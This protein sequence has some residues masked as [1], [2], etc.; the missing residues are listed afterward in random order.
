MAVIRKTKK[1]YGMQRGGFFGKLKGLLKKPQKTVVAFKNPM[2]EGLKPNLH[3]NPLYNSKGE[4]AQHYETVSNNQKSISRQGSHSAINAFSKT[5]PKLPLTPTELDTNK[6]KD[7]IIA[8]QKAYIVNPLEIKTSSPI[9]TSSGEKTSFYNIKKMKNYLVKQG[10]TGNNH[11]NRLISDI[12]QTG[13]SEVSKQAKLDFNKQAFR[14]AREFSTEKFIKSMPSERQE[15]IRNYI[16]KPDSYMKNVRSKTLNKYF[17]NI[18]PNNNSKRRV[19]AELIEIGKKQGEFARLSRKNIEDA[20]TKVNKIREIRKRFSIENTLGKT[21]TVRQN[22][23]KEST[24]AK[25]GTNSELYK[26]LPNVGNNSGYMTVAS[27]KTNNT[28]YGYFEVSGEKPE[29]HGYIVVEPNTSSDYLNIS[30]S[31][32]KKSSTARTP[33]S[34]RL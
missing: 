2:F 4:R 8:L 3:K 19:V 28:R 11:I 14:D 16:N 32:P 24:G 27:Q 21:T 7:A 33:M 12:S 17:E 23:L 22:L 34:K 9:K 29:N 5:P 31:S 25:S 13:L 20:I 10:I 15:K 18:G 30:S 6:S 1:K 26:E